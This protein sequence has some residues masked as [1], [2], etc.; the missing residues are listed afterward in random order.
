MSQTTYAEQSE[1]CSENQARSSGTV[2]DKVRQENTPDTTTQ[3]SPQDDSLQLCCDD[4]GSLSSL[5]FRTA[6]DDLAS[7]LGISND[8]RMNQIC[9]RSV[10]DQ[11][12]IDEFTGGDWL[13]DHNQQHTTFD[14]KEFNKQ[15][16]RN[17]CAAYAQ[18]GNNPKFWNTLQT[19]MGEDLQ[20]MVEAGKMSP[21]AKSAFDKVF[22]KAV[23][24]VYATDGQ[25]PCPNVF[26]KKLEDR[27]ISDIKKESGLPKPPKPDGADDQPDG[28]DDTPTPTDG[29]VQQ[30]RERLH[31]SMEGHLHGD[32]LARFDKMCAEFEKHAA[33]RI[34]QQVAAGKDRAT[35]EKEWNDKLKNTYNS[36]NDMVT[37]NPAGAPFDQATRAKMAE[38]A[39][40]LFMNPSES[41]QGAHGTCWIESVINLV[42]LNNNPDDMAR[43]LKEVTT[44]GSYKDNNGKQY[45]IPRQL[46]QFPGEEK[47]WTISNSANGTRSPVGAI[48]DR[49]LSFMGGRM[50]G[51]TNGGTPSS[52]QNLIEKVTGER[53][54]QI[55]NIRS[56]HLTDSDI[57]RINSREYRQAM[58]EQGGVILLGP[59][60]MFVA[61]MAKEHGQ[62]QIRGD[63]Q[64]GDRNEQVIGTL[65]DLNAWNVTNTRQKYKPDDPDMTIAND[66]SL[67]NRK[68][69]TTYASTTRTYN[70]SY[71]S[72]G[73]AVM[74]RGT[75]S[76]AEVYDDTNPLIP[77][78]G[79]RRR[80]EDDDGYKPQPNGRRTI[81][82]F[83][84]DKYR[85]TL[86]RMDRVR[87][88]LARSSQ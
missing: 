64:W 88:R 32:R 12:M 47:D 41:N 66:T 5:S 46:L 13:Q 70:S 42:G 48:F 34:E 51:G 73:E 74:P 18:E 2:S 63:N 16:C 9:G 77:V 60:H 33:E 45:N 57:A 7:Y 28:A 61:T 17:I 69:Y 75:R 27:L 67:N 82:Q 65:T 56:N 58:L 80:D 29:S 1:C 54:M 81:R 43:L 35:V 72:S 15:F 24:D 19:M 6:N 83:D 4:N 50:D 26:W 39:M 85:E 8:S 68:S 20:K 76:D 87:T 52:A 40:F 62:W 78:G 23:R 44:T 38:N 25:N 30:A 59:G 21:E 14:T 37:Q 79:P 49:V 3:S 11:M 22:M 71:Y 36:L 86:E 53:A 10:Y 55:V 84:E 31:K